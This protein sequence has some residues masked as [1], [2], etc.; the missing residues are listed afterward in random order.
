MLAE[1]LAAIKSMVRPLQA[2]LRSYI[3]NYGV[4][5]SEVRERRQ[6]WRDVWPIAAFHFQ[7]I[8]QCF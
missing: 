5:P 2:S 3:T 4:P 8:V 6:F 7:L 1:C